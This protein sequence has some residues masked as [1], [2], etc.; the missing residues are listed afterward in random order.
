MRFELTDAFDAPVE[1]ILACYVDPDF[2]GNLEGL[3]NIG[4]PQVVGHTRDGS[5]VTMRVHYRF[6]RVLSAGVRAA[7]DPAKLSWVEETVWDLDAGV[8]RSHL[9]PDNYADRFSA[10]ATRTHSPTESGGCARAIAG[11]VK[12]RMP[13]VGGKVEAAVVEGLEE[14]LAA[15]AAVVQRLTTT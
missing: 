14:Y 8:G 5:T 6:T 9:L 11:E 2:Y 12:V 1:A 7:V 10:S 3:P 4:T 13:L 15:E